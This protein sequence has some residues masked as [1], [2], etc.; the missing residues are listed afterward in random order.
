MVLE[1]CKMAKVHAENE[2]HENIQ[3]RA[4][5]TGFS[6]M[7]DPRMTEVSLKASAQYEMNLEYLRP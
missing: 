6:E 5:T 2:T 7:S 1:R 3:C 4:R